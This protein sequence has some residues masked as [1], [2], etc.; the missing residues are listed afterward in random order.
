LYNL[1][2]KQPD[3]FDK[4]HKVTLASID[5]EHSFKEMLKL[6]IRLYENILKDIS[7]HPNSQIHLTFNDNQE[8]QNDLNNMMFDD[9]P[10]NIKNNCGYECDIKANKF[11][12]QIISE[13]IMKICRDF[14]SVTSD[15]VEK[16]THYRSLG[17]RR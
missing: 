6:L 10:T 1:I 9:E 17:Q 14:S 5:K 11:V 8:F 12:F 7:S 13:T 3:L 16:R 2:V 15:N 4:F